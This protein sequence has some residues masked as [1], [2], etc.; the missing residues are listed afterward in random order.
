VPHGVEV[1]SLSFGPSPSDIL[2]EK[3]LR[4]PGRRGLLHIVMGDRSGGGRG[5]FAL[6]SG[7]LLSG[8][9]LA[10]PLAVRADQDPTLCGSGGCELLVGVG[11]TYHFWAKTNGIVVPFI[12][13][14]GYGRYELGAFRFTNPQMV[15]FNET[16]PPQRAAGPYWG[17]SLSRRWRLFG[18]G[19]VGMFLG[20]GLNYKTETDQLNST[21]WNF[22]EQLAVRWRISHAVGMELAIR[23]WSNAG[24]KLPNRGQDFATLTL[25]F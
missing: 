9:L 25:I 12:F 23:H 1:V 8:G 13:D 6:L 10:A 22:A 15:E 19:S 11:G 17:F 4:A 16:F 7:V 20:I 2:V 18:R 5:V 14:F 3:A 24:I 21:H